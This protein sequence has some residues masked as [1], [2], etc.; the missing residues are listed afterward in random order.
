MMRAVS[1]FESN[2]IRITRT[3][4]GH[5][6]VAEVLPLLVRRHD[7]PRCLSRACVDLIEDALAKGLTARLARLGWQP[8][9]TLDD[10][11]VVSGRVWDRT[12]VDRRALVFSS[13]LLRWLLWLTADNFADPRKPPKLDSDRITWGDRVFAWQAFDT[14][15][16]TQGVG[17]LL[18]QPL[19]Q[20]HGLI[21]L[22]FPDLRA[23]QY[24]MSKPE[25]DLWTQRGHSWVLESCDELLADRWVQIEREKRQSANLDAVRRVSRNQQQVLQALLSTVSKRQRW[26]LTRWMLIATGRVLL[27]IDEDRSYLPQLDVRRL[28]VSERSTLLEEALTLF[29]SLNRLHQHHVDSRNIGFTDDNYHASQLWKSDWERLHGDEIHSRSQ[30]LVARH[31]LLQFTRPT[32]VR[33]ES[34]L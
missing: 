12:A 22:V 24:V 11:T 9:R 28:R 6:S 18:R 8:R 34:H 10:D 33:V 5:G 27:E 4:V 15:H 14:L 29:H 20:N 31:Q 17:T 16:N 26:D 32:G 25:I 3:L 13:E 7:P 2:L 30:A 19:F 1:H 23:E 21:A